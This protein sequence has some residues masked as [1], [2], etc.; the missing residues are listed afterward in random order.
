MSDAKTEPRSWRVPLQILEYFEMPRNPEFVD[1]IEQSAFDALQSELA[2][3]RN[4]LR[5]EINGHA[6]AQEEI[7]NLKA[8]LKKC[9]EQLTKL[10][11]SAN[12]ADEVL[13]ERR[14]I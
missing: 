1:V 12:H 13:C 4:S 7:A 14:K 8:A 5:I 6:A 9:S 11:F 10:G 2:D 3:C